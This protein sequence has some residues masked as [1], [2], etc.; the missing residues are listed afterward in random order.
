MA[1]LGSCLPRCLQWEDN[2]RK[3]LIAALLGVLIS[4]SLASA[5]E[6][7]CSARKSACEAGTLGRAHEHKWDRS[8]LERRLAICSNAYSGCL[9]SGTWIT[10]GAFGKEF[11][12]VARR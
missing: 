11:Y 3:S 1:H 10:Y 4:A 12:N 6:L 7:T 5:G 8:L 9:S 2:M